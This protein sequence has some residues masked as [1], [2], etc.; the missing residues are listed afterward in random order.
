MSEIKVSWPTLAAASIKAA[1][2]GRSAQT[3]SF[4]CKKSFKKGSQNTLNVKLAP[5]D[6]AN[7]LSHKT[8]SRYEKLMDKNRNR[9]LFIISK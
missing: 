3:D 5:A 6:K 7:D 8:P 2:D 9:N 1:G 4:L